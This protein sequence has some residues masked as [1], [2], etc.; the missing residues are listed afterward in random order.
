M[1]D[2]EIKEEVW[3]GSVPICLSLA[4]SEIVTVTAPV[5]VYVMAPRGG[6][7]PLVTQAVRER[8]VRHAPSGFASAEMW[9]E[10]AADGAPLRWHLPIGVLYDAHCEDGALMWSVTVHFQNFPAAELL[11]CASLDDVQ[12]H[13]MNALKEAICIKHG[14]VALIN[15]LTQKEVLD[16]WVG[17][18]TNDEKRFAAV[19]AKLE[20]AAP[21]SVPV[22]VI[23]PRKPVLQDIVDPAG[24]LGSTLAT[25]LSVPVSSL[26]QDSI[27]V[28]G[29]HPSLESPISWLAASCAH[30][31]NF[32]YIVVKSP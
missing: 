12:S 13:F 20:A 18:A 16:L 15:D 24:T 29:V 6:Y 25:L 2:R 28:Q 9:F 3:K 19:N 11:H 32:L 1:V 14:S 21:K 22:R 31:D 26:A 4:A 17:V 27:F 23:R 7:L 30:P 5:P 10:S 8:F